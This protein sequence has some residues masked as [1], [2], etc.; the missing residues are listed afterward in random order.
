MK[1][2]KWVMLF[3]C[4][5][6]MSA[7]VSCGEHGAEES[8]HESGSVQTEEILSSEEREIAENQKF[9]ETVSY[10]R[11]T[12]TG[13]DTPYFVG[14]WFEKKINGVKHT[15]TLTDGSAF[16][17][18]IDGAESFDLNFTVITS[19]EEPYFAYS[20]D[21]GEPIRQ[22]IT[23]KT[24]RLP[25]NGKHTVRIIAD[26]MTESEN[27]WKNEKGFALKS[28]TPSEGGKIYGIRPENKIIFYYG[29]SITEGVRALNMSATSNGNSATNAYPWFCSE[30]LG[31][32]TYSVGYGASG[33]TVSGSFHT[34]QNAI[35]YNSDGRKVDDGIIP[36]VIVINHGTNDRNASAD[37]FKAELAKAIARLREKYP[38]AP[39]VYM[40][41]FGQYHAGAI[42]ET[43]GGFE[44]AYVVPTD[45]W[46][47]TFTDVFHPDSDGAKTAGENL[48]EELIRILGEDFF[49]GVAQ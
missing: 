25:D 31:A 26:G 16:Y 37:V 11:Y 42:T 14:R 38:D 48:A 23:E 4:F 46:N 47:L 45:E 30:K 44:N 17:F 12:L 36:D 29:D 39:I 24:V 49:G 8:A 33:V 9:L 15:V 20:I 3:L 28:V 32:V 6:M 34:F 35:D 21:G 27:K 1:R 19:K 43:V 18:L 13:E 5:F 41:P 10:L 22:H 7:L 2:I 40:I